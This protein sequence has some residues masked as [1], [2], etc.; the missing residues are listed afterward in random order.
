MAAFVAG[1]PIDPTTEA[2]AGCQLDGWVVRAHSVPEQGH[3]VLMSSSE[4]ARLSRI[5]FPKVQPSIWRSCNAAT[6]L[7]FVDN[8]RRLLEI[9]LYYIHIV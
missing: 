4:D 7:G 5:A 3:H 9:P 2:E 6:T 8:L 1:A